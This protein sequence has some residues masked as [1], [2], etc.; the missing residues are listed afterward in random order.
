MIEAQDQLAVGFVVLVIAG[1]IGWTLIRDRL[2]E[3]LQ[4]LGKWL[5]IAGAA[6]FAL[7]FWPRIAAEIA[8]PAPPAAAAT[9][10]IPRGNDGHYAAT[11]QI[12]GEAVRFLVDTG[13]G[14]VLMTVADAERV[15]VN[16]SALD[17]SQVVNTA[18]GAM[19]VARARVEDVRLGEIVDPVLFVVVAEGA[20]GSNLLG[21]DYLSQFREVSFEGDTLRLVR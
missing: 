8:P 1:L 16:T 12:N 2:G 18:N 17:F 7:L 4:G 3:S 13:A 21:M 6:G 11:L 5:L 14:P 19:R 9:V 10:E 20:A 15:G